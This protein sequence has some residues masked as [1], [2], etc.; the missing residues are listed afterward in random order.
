MKW[1]M[2]KV[3]FKCRNDIDKVFCKIFICNFVLNK[4]CIY[5]VILRFKFICSRI[6]CKKIFFEKLDKNIC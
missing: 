2:F 4:M 1:N 6:K 5:Y 3:L